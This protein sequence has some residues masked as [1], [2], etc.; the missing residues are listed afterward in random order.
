MTAVDWKGK[1]YWLIGA[2]EG[3]G[4]SLAVQMRAAG[5]NLILS[6][7]S[8]A[9]LAAAARSVASDL[10]GVMTVPVDVADDA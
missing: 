6:A 7:R 3:L 1:R 5:A 4:L 8:E 9:A 10:D 2:S